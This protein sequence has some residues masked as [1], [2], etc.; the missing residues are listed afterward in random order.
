MVVFPGV[1][2]PP[3]DAWMLVQAMRD[4][5]LAQKADVLD[6][7]TGSGV[8]AIAAAL[9]G[10]SSVTAVDISRRAA[11][12]ARLNATLNRARV[13]VLRG[14]L[15]EPVGG[16]RFG[17]IVA[18][19]PYLPSAGDELPSG[20]AQ[21]A[22]EGGA[23]G[24]LLVDRFCREAPGHLADGGR[25]LMVHS[26][27]T[28]EQASLEALAGAGLD[29]EVLARSRGPLGPIAAARAPLL[30]RRGLLAPGQREEEMLVIAAGRPGP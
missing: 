21:R 22:W 28:G 23:D 2:R 8:L 1:L 12:N 16:R 29:A 13:S 9:Q 26:S 11:L 25:I 20:G 3:S 4:R 30:E 19:P 7:F 18:N 5:R 17:L 10:A 14:D 6:V 27:L 15:F 24:R